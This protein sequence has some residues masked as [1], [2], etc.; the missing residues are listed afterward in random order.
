MKKIATG[1]VLAML[2]LT[3]VTA[4]NAQ[5]QANV[6]GTWDMKVE[7]S[8]GN[9]T[10]V[11]ELKHLTETTL[12]GTYKGRLGESKVSGTVKLNIIHLEFE[13][14]GGLIEYDGTVEGETMKGKIKFS[15]MGEGTFTGTRK[16]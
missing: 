5:K 14:S 2:L 11:F 1:I 4:A 6:K 10:P 16:K 8:L 7:S 3:S 12:E 15:S 9:G 13:I